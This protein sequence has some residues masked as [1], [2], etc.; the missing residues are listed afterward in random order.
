MEVLEFLFDAEGGARSSSYKK[1]KQHFQHVYS[2]YSR[3][4]ALIKNFHRIEAENKAA[5]AQEARDRDCDDD[6]PEVEGEEEWRIDPL[7]G[8]GEFMA[9]KRRPTIAIPVSTG[10]EIDRWL[11]EPNLPLDSTPDDIQRYMRDRRTDFPIIIQIARDF[12][13]IPATSSPS[14]RV[15]NYAGNLITKKR[16]RITSEN[17]RY[18]LYLRS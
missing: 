15:F 11:T 17:I 13:A 5:D 10:N 12:Q 1:G 16:T 8:F 14:E 7:Y 6:S 2:D 18:V 9:T 4:A 3:R